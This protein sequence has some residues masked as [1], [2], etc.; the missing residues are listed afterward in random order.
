MSFLFLAQ[1]LQLPAFGL[2]TPAAVHFSDHSVRD[3]DRVRAQA[4]SM[5]ASIG[6]G[7]VFGSLG[8]GFM[9]DRWGLHNMLLVSTCL[10]FIGFLIMFFVLYKKPAKVNI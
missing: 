2:Y 9:L 3:A 5:V 8:G 7:N 4:I 6:I 10:G 1:V